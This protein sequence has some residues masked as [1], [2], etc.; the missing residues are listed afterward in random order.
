MKRLGASIIF[1]NDQQKILLFLR[2]DKVGLPYPNMWDVP[3]GHVETSETPSDCIVREMKEEMNIDL[4]D[5][6]LFCKKEF[7]DR[8]E[9][10]Y[11]KQ[12]NLEISEIELMEGQRLKWFSRGEAAQTK[13]A[14]GFNEIVE[15]FF[16]KYKLSLIEGNT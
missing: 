8:I 7:D 16:N 14:Y 4:H 12:T 11:W 9:Y 5:F 10:T 6:Q 3:G 1:V 2:D 15:R 13:L